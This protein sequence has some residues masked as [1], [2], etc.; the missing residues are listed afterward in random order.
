MTTPKTGQGSFGGK[1]GI[2]GFDK[3]PQNINR[4]GRPRSLFRKLLEE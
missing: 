1:R 4:N 2:N 3:N